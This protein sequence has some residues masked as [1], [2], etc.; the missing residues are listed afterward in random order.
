MCVCVG[1]RRAAG[2]RRRQDRTGRTSCG[3]ASRGSAWRQ[4]LGQVRS[5]GHAGLGGWQQAPR[6]A[7][8]GLPRGSPAGCRGQQGQCR[9]HRASRLWA[10][11][12]PAA[13]AHL[14]QLQLVKLLGLRQQLAAGR[15][16]AVRQECVR[17]Q[18]CRQ[19]RHRP[20]RWWAGHGG[21]T[22]R[23]QHRADEAR[24]LLT[25]R[26]A[27]P[28]PAAWSSGRSF[29]AAACDAQARRVAAGAA[30]L[31]TGMRNRGAGGVRGAGR[32]GEARCLG[33]SCPPVLGSHGGLE[34]SGIALGLQQAGR[35]STVRSARGAPQAG[36][37]DALADT[38]RLDGLLLDLELVLEPAAGNS[39]GSALGAGP[40]AG[41]AAPTW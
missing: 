20:Q 2:G 38:H 8:G 5:G 11:P 22:Q 28:S 6:E 3:P 29:A 9:G 32:A 18:P 39:P 7:R 17:V 40:A 4:G 30:W 23:Q 24:E 14:V 27:W 21:R 34:G 25:R 16:A 12:L 41:S 36:A 26:R 13:A 33:I 35:G 31:S 19:R 37:I 1:C 10:Q 15:M